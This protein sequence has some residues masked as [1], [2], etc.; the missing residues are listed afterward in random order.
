MASY[1]AYR[2]SASLGSMGDNAGNERRGTDRWPARSALTGLLA[3]AIGIERTDR[4]RLAELEHGYRLGVAAR[5]LGPLLIDYHTAQFVPGSV[6]R[7]PDSRADAM[8][9]ARRKHRLGTL[10]SER[11]YHEACVFDVVVC[12]GE[13]ARWTLEELAE[14]LRE[15]RFLPYFGRKACPLD[16]PMYPLVLEAENAVAALAEYADRRPSLDGDD[17]PDVPLVARFDP[18]MLDEDRR[19]RGRRVRRRDGV[20]DRQRWLFADREV[21]EVR[22]DAGGVP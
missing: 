9:V 14:R 17:G 22:L 12:A 5:S 4:A 10:L 7:R 18:E 1:L 13:R 16:R 15:P 20:V 11:E 3:G 8:A 6:A 19:G 2:L 21:I